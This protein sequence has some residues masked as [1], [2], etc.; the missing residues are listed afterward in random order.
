MCVELFHIGSI[1]IYGYGLMLALG[2]VSAITMFYLRG[3]RYGIDPDMLFNA[4]FIGIVAGL[5]GAKLMYWLTDIKA[6]V[7][8]PKIL[9][10][11]GDGFVVYGGLITGILAPWIYVSKMKKQTFLDKLDLAMPSICLGQAFGRVGCFLGGCCYGAAAPEGA[12]YAVHFPAGCS[13]PEGIGL[14]PTQVMSVILNLLLMA[15]LLFM[16]NRSRFRGQIL[17]FYMMLYSVGRFFIEFIRDDPRGTVWVF[18]TSQFIGIL[19][20]ALAVVLYVIFMKKDL[21]PLRRL[22]AADL[23]ALKAGEKTYDV[24]R[25]EKPGEEAE[26]DTEEAEE[27]AEEPAE[28]A[29]EDAA[30]DAAEA[31]EEAVEETVVETEANAEEAL[32]TVAKTS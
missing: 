10:S 29:T 31:L 5:I 30:E 9:L 3:R 27:T 11:L 17:C 23:L 4:A 14:Y 2:V 32:E 18:S 26:E 15:F 28:Q 24:F 8:N 12:W 20:F 1:T 21:T 25:L 6:I 19:V 16:T 22:S 13:A 7:E